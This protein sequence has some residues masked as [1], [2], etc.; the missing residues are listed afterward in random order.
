VGVVDALGSL[1]ALSLRAVVG[2]RE[3]VAAVVLEDECSSR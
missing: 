2:E 3:I 1:R